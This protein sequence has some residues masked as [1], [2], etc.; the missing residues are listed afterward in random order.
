[1][2]IDQSLIC[3]S[4]EQDPYGELK[5]FAGSGSH[6]LATAICRKLGVQIA[7]S[8]TKIFSEGNIFVRVLETCVGEMFSSFRAQISR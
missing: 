6:R 2:A 8:E 4:K 5:I 7:E 1:M 3:S